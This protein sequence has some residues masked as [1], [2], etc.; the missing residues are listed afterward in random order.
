[1]VYNEGADP[2]YPRCDQAPFA[3]LGATTQGTQ[4]VC[5]LRHCLGDRTPTRQPVVPAPPP[6][7]VAPSSG[8]HG[9]KLGAPI[10]ISR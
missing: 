3:I 1:M 6:L 4:R 9:P 10:V 8:G 5:C 2:A 7:P